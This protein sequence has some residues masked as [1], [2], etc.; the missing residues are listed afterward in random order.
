MVG[1]GE[2]DEAVTLCVEEV[3]VG[4]EV[5]GL[6]VVV[7]VMGVLDGDGVVVVVSTGVEAVETTVLVTVTSVV[8]TF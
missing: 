1:V 4:L 2:V 3:G 6:D 7:V 8:E 5:G